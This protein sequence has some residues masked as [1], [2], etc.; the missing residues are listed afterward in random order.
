MMGL[1]VIMV[2]FSHVS[3]DFLI[4]LFIYL[5][6]LYDYLNL[7]NAASKKLFEPVLDVL[8]QILNENEK[9]L[10]TPSE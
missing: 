5:L 4:Y 3:A 10:L 9:E 8:N 2:S 1:L 7:T 6:D